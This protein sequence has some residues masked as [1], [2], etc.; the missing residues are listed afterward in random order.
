MCLRPSKRAHVCG[1]NFCY[2]VLLAHVRLCKIA[3]SSVDDLS[4]RG[5]PHSSS[6]DPHLVVLCVVSRGYDPHSLVWHAPP[7]T[8][9]VPHDIKAWT[10]DICLLIVKYFCPTMQRLVTLGPVYIPLM[11]CDLCVTVL[12]FVFWSCECVCSVFCLKAAT[13]ATSMIRWKS[14]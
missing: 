10:D 3:L 5:A 11:K 4:T 7:G 14:W 12:H 1:V 13:I 8:Q 9:E 6:A 2:C